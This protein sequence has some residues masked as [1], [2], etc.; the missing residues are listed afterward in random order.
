MYT[1]KE[2]FMLDKIVDK[3]NE[4]NV[5][6]NITNTNRKKNV[7]RTTIIASN[8]PQKACVYLCIFRSLYAYFIS[9]EHFLIVYFEY[10]GY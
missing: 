10:D 5:M 8:E 6:Y 7:S 1:K 4:T 2:Y 9:V 3:L